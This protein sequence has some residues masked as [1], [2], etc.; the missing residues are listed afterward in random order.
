MRA[1][2]TDVITRLHIDVTRNATDD[3]NLFHDARKWRRISRNPFEGP[4]AL[5]FQLEAYIEHK[6]LQYRKLHNETAFIAKEKL[7]FSNYQFSFAGAVKAGQSIEID[8]KK[9]L[10]NDVAQTILGNR[11]SVKADGK[12]AITGFKKESRA[13]LFLDAAEIPDFG[14]LI[15]YPDRSFLPGGA[16][17]MKRKFMNTSNAKNFLCGSLADQSDYFDELEDKASF[18]EIFPCSLISCALLE[19]AIKENHD[20]EKNPMVYTSHKISIDRIRLLR[21]KS[22]D[23]LHIL[24]KPKDSDKHECAADHEY[25]YECYGL[26]K[27]NAIL[28]RALISLA[29]LDKVLKSLG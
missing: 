2:N 10:V 16:F 9:T 8:I 23:V 22:N 12:L 18:P 26:I 5:G 6:I 15:H 19:K 29:P 21:L 24:I 14:D 4:I 25:V 17:F 13:A 7:H 11:V 20:F 27:N 28:Y 1:T 3:F